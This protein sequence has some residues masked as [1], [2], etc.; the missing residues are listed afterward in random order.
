MQA[1]IFRFANIVGERGT[2]G[3]LVDF[4]NKLKKNPAELEILG[5]GQQL[6]SYLDVRDCVDAM[7]Y[8][9]DNSGDQTNIFNIGSTDAVDVTEIADIVAEKMGLSD[10]IYKYTGGFGGRAGGEMSKSCSFP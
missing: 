8:A 4:I 9:V 7:I 6:K 2:H 5:S 1:W 10:V 3:V